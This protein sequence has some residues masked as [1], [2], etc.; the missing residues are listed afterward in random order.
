MA[1]ELEMANGKANFAYN[2]GNGKPWHLLG[3]PVDG[4]QTADEMLRIAN[5]DYE[6]WTEPVYVKDERTGEFVEVDKRYA[7]VR[8]NPNTEELQPFEVFTQRYT[9]LQNREVLEKALAIVGAANG[10]AVVDTLGVLFDGRQFFAS[11]DLGSL[12]ID[13]AGINDRISRNLLVKTSHDGS[14]PVVI[15][16]TDIRAV[17]NNT[18]RFAEDEARSVFKARHTPNHEE[19]FEEAQAILGL[20]T[21]WAESFKAQ[22]QELLEIEV[23]L[24]SARFDKVMETLYPSADADTDRKKNNRDEIVTKMS[25]AFAN[26][27]NA[28]A[29]G[30]NGWGLFNAI[31][32]VYDWGGKGSQTDKAVK[33]LDEAGLV[34]KR[35][36]KAQDAILALAN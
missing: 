8:I 12:V 27:R 36:L 16:N 2:I 33:S 15:A 34:T 18:V 19:R 20:S 5:A 25:L 9:T 3:T 26:E 13:P 11:I 32:E 23:G 22:A 30:E 31:T 14:S 21:A 17:C 29:V 35:K 6:V 10:D 1:H 28:Q 24:N 7:T 4:L